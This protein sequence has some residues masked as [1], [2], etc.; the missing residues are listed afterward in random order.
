MTHF[1]KIS[2]MDELKS[3]KEN[4]ANCAESTVIRWKD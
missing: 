1:A 4:S 2:Q 3:K